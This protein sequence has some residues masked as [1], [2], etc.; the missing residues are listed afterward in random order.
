MRRT[1]LYLL[2]AAC[3]G[4]PEPGAPEPVAPERTAWLQ[5]PSSSRGVAAPVAPE[6]LTV[7]FLNVG[8]FLLTRGKEQVMTPPLFTRP[9]L[10]DTQTGKEVR[11][12]VAAISA[13]FPRERVA[14]LKAVLV[15]HAH[16]DHLI[17]APAVQANAPAPVLY[18]SSTVKNLL[19]ALSP[20]RP[21][22][23]GPA[24][25]RAVTLEDERVVALDGVAD[26]RNC[27]SLKPDGAPLEGR[28]VRVPG[29]NIRFMAL[30]SSHPDQFGPVHFAPGDVTAPQC[31]LPLRA[32]GWR[33]G[34]TLSYLVDFLDPVTGTPTMR[35][36][37]QDS[38]GR[39]PVGNVPPELLEE[40][41]IDVALLC[42]GSSG[43]VPDEPSRTLAALSPR[44]A[45]G[46]HWEDFFRS[47]DAAPAP[48]PFLDLQEWKASAAAAMGDSSR[49]VVPMP[50]QVFVIE[51]P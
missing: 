24:G 12:D 44:F 48:I 33:E 16:Y 49:A 51:A 21:P 29:S 14:G 8:G 11:S 6:P 5:P 18:G 20:A 7:E 17:D 27:P 37:Y 31:E 28:W 19:A 22:G 15:G 4:S 39:D 43:N 30:C 26:Y 2:C 25:P 3:A 42:V 41:R 45:L 9:S 35:V 1:L 34:L 40:R 38:P 13:R 32:D 46:G 23:C 10:L 36:Y 47:A 50:G